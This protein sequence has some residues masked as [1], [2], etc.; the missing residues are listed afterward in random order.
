MKNPQFNQDNRPS[1]R[2]DLASRGR[3]RGRGHLK[4]QN[5]DPKDH[6]STANIT[7]ET[8]ALK[9]ALKSKRTKLESSKRQP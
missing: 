3:G 1:T 6:T 7:E 2:G 9:R 5:L 8:I 4:I